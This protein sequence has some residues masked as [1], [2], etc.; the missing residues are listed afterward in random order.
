MGNY[1]ELN[2]ELFSLDNITHVYKSNSKKEIKIFY[3]RYDYFTTEPYKDTKEME[4]D[5]IK[6]KNKL[7]L[8]WT[9]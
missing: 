6:L 1:I 2:G 4:K 8:K 7:L 3:Y 5:Y 9:F